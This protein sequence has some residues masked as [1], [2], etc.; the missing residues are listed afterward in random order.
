MNAEIALFVMAGFVGG[1]VNAAA[2]GAKLF[3]FPM[4]LASGV[5]PVAANITQSV[6]LWPA[7]LPAVWV[8]R[9][10]IMADARSLVRQMI[11]ALGAALAGSLVMV[12]SSDAAFVAVVPVLLLISVAAIV[13]GP[14]TTSLMQWA[15][16]GDRLKVA[17]SVMLVA[18]GFYGG[19]FGAGMGFMLLAVLAAPGG[20][21][22][23]RVN[24]AKNLFAFGIQS[25]AIPPM[26]LSGLINWLAVLC[27]LTGGILGGYLGA[28]LT[29]R[30]PDRAL[31]IAVATLGV[32]LTLSFLLR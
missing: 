27:V 30:L 26:A 16:P 9:R 12:N 14:K 6:A 24:G 10:E 20:L 1:I 23:G 2:G 31:R 22:L 17:T 29:K 5:P 3:V 21:G 19:Y 7:Q 25:V 15:F 8:Y 18:I 13:F 11:P 32:G 4:L 28:K